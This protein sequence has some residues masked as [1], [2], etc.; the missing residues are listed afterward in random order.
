MAALTHVH[1]HACLK[2]EELCLSVTA[3]NRQEIS[4]KVWLLINSGVKRR[5]NSMYCL[6][7]WLWCHTGCDDSSD[8]YSKKQ[9]VC[10]RTHTSYIIYFSRRVCRIQFAETGTNAGNIGWICRQH[11]LWI[12]RGSITHTNCSTSFKSEQYSWNNIITMVHNFPK[13]SMRLGGGLCVGTICR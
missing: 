13:I 9:E 4:Q 12:W 7:E 8:C 1:V 5:V 11:R 3:K 6:L 2:E 10:N